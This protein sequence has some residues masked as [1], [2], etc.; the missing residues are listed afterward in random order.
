VARAERL[1]A[2]ALQPHDRREELLRGNQSVERVGGVRQVSQLPARLLP[3]VCEE[4]L[5]SA[6]HRLAER[7]HRIEVLAESLL[8]RALPGDWSMRR[9]CCTTSPRPYAIHATEGR[10]RAARPVSW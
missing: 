2:L 6:R 7:E 3:E 4:V 5:P 10:R 8:V 9:R 1:T